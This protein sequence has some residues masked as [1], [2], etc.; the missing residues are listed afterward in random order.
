M[1]LTQP[2]YTLSNWYFI[3]I[4]LMLAVSTYLAMPDTDNQ[5]DAG[6][7]LSFL[8]MVGLAVVQ[9][10][11][12][13]YIYGQRIKGA[14]RSIRLVPRFILYYAI[15]FIWM[16]TITVLFDTDH[17]IMGLTTISLSILVF[18]FLLSSSYFRARYS[19][20][21][22]WFYLTV[23]FL[24]LCICVQYKNIYSIA[25]FL[26]TDKS[27][28]AVSYTPL[29]I[30]P[31]LLLSPSRIIRYTSILLTT[32]IIISA[33]KRGGILAL[34]ACLMVYV[35]VKQ[36]VSGTSK[37]R[38]ITIILAVVAAM[39]GVVYYIMENTDNNIIERIQNISDDGGS[40]RDI[41]WVDTYNNIHNRDVGYQ[42]A[43]NGY[44]SALK[45]S[46]LQLP[47]HNDFL[48]IWHDFGLIGIVLY[49]I[50][51]FSLGLY[52]LRLM[53]RKSK[54]A[55]HMA[56]ALTYYFI[57]SMTS[58]VVF[59]FWMALVMFSVG[60]VAGLADRELENDPNEI[61]IYDNENNSNNAN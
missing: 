27:H 30:L 1:N 14:T 15:Y 24:M 26:D 8:A 53:K 16:T 43:G 38:Q 25:N 31:I 19:E 34:G 55:P 59:Y 48:E 4:L 50:A 37:L 60:I 10:P 35:F 46:V 23:I 11:L 56:M 52:T 5:A 32:I 2:K 6:S 44:R 61:T 9:I 17:N 39:G 12:L 41:L 28:I 18:T 7:G 47:A 57:F 3:G 58:I 51:L 22:S 45:V 13:I 40:G 54:Y 29:F 21:D 36:Y 42:L 49:G 33:V 20:L